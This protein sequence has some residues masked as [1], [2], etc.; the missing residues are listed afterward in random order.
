MGKAKKAIQNILAA[1][2]RYEAVRIRVMTDLGLTQFELET[3]IKELE[4]RIRSLRQGRGGSGGRGGGRG[5]G[6]GAGGPGG[7][8]GG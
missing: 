8:G 6:R 3:I 5:S 4:A 7:P 2:K 1:T